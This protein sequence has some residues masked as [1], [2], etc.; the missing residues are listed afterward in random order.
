MLGRLSSRALHLGKHFVY[1]SCHCVG[2]RPD[3]GSTT[4]L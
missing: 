4:G 3:V 2:N 1:I